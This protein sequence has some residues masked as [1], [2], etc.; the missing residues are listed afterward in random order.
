MSVPNVLKQCIACVTILFC[1]N[2]VQAQYNTGMATG[3]YAGIAGIWMNPANA[4]DSRYKFDIN[5][6][7]I[8]SYYNN[9]YL[10]VKNGALVR[11]I[12]YKSPYNGSFADVKKDLLEEGT[13]NG[14]VFAKTES[15]IHMPLSFLVT[16]GKRSAIAFTMN[17][18]TINSVD[19]L[20]P[21]TAKMLY[22]ELGNPAL[23]NVAMNNDG[24]R[25]NF[26]NWQE[27]GLTYGRVIINSGSLFFKAAVTGK[28]LGAGAAGF[29]QTDKATVSFKDNHTMS[30]NSP[31]IQY[32]RTTTADIGQFSRKNLFNNLE[33]QSWGF[34]A[35]F[36]FEW[37][38]KINK[39]KYVNDDQKMQLRKDQNKYVLRIGF[40]VVDLGQFTF[41]RKP[42]TNDH[43]ANINNW[44]FGTVKATNLSDFDTAYSKQI[45]YIPGA[46]STFTYRLPGAAIINADLHL[47]GGFYI[48]VASKQPLAGYGSK[49]TTY[50]QADRWT[51]ITP[52]FEGKF[53]GIYIPVTRVNNQTNVGATIKFGPLYV[54]SNNLAQLLSNQKS[55]E[56]DFHAGLRL[57]ILQGKPPRIFKS[58]NRY[59]GDEISERD[60]KK[61]LDSLSN[62]V[63]ILKALQAQS[64]NQR[65]VIIINNADGTTSEVIKNSGD[66]IYIANRNNDVNTSNNRN[67]ESKSSSVQSGTVKIEK[68]T[69]SEYLL[70]Q[71]AESHLEVKRLKEEADD[72]KLTNKSKKSK[73]SKTSETTTANN[74]ELEQ[75]L[76]KLRKQNRNQNA[77]IIATATA[78]TAATVAAISANND[79]KPKDSAVIKNFAD[80]TKAAM[81]KDSVHQNTS[82]DSAALIVLDSSKSVRKISDTI[83]IRDTIYITKELPAKEQITEQIPAGTLPVYEPVYFANANS[84]LN[85]ADIERIKKMADELNK[86]QRVVIELTGCTDAS[87]SVAANKKIAL[88]RATAVQGILLKVGID[89]NRVTIKTV[90]GNKGIKSS[91]KDR[92]VDILVKEQ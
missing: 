32:G 56:A 4:V 16:T 85:R 31:L 9:N 19:S 8:N 41:N 89:K 50:I 68:D 24:L 83:I 29:I 49:A 7:G 64:I 20:N 90:A 39:F 81:Q 30:L 2:T 25:Q 47:F 87:G 76:E 21:L 86:N 1:T 44:N 28:W 48:N 80:T 63:K 78:A 42:L 10:L 67:A 38:E 62:E 22:D 12:F 66:S 26:L 92:R 11:R 3:N 37:R 73:R 59:T 43:S 6:I 52:R 57:S 33:D 23:Q 60:S 35:G 55:M 54:G 5:I 18:R 82:I 69:T 51:V 46:S 13:V 27:V 71:L 53:L 45:N 91:A 34:D 88:K 72:S 61:T 14:K 77:A 58:F 84:S 65:P 17:N 15:T 79:K 75:E 40:S 74:E 36:V 70:R